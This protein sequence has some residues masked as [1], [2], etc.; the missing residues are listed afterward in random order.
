VLLRHCDEV[1]KLPD[2]HGKGYTESV[3]HWQ[4]KS[5]LTVYP[6]CRRVGLPE[7]MRGATVNWRVS[8]VFQNSRS[9]VQ[10]GGSTASRGTG[11]C[12]P[13]P[14]FSWWWEE[15]ANTAVDSSPC[16]PLFGSHDFD[17]TIVGGGYTGLWTALTLRERAP[18]LGVALLEAE[19]CGAGASGKNGGFL[20]GYWEGFPKIS[21]L[22]GAA[23]A[24]RLARMGSTA[25]QAIIDFCRA[26][27]EDVWLTTNGIYK[28]AT[29]RAQEAVIDGAI[30][31][32]AELPA[33][34]QP[35]V[36]GAAEM[37]RRFSTDSFRRAAW[38][39]EGGTVHP[40]RLVQA[41]K[42]AALE[43]GVRIFES[44][45][46]VDTDAQ[47][48]RTVLTTSAGRITSGHVVMATNA[49]L[50]DRLPYS[51]HVTNLGS[52]VVVTEPVPEVLKA[53]EGADG[54]A[55]KDARMFLNWVRTTPDG[56]LVMGNGAGP[57]S[58]RG[59]VSAVHTQ[60]Q[61][62]ADRAVE[63]LN[64]FFPA[65]VD[66]KVAQAW[67]GAIDMSADRLPFFGTLPGTRVHYGLGY[68]GHG[69]N[70]AW[71]GGQV[72]ASLALGQRDEWTTSLFC[73]RPLAK[74]PTEPFRYVGG[75]LIHRSMLR[76]EDALDAGTRPP[77]AVSTVA[78]LP[79]WLGLRIGVR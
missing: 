18:H 12:A 76:Y 46:V 48:H 72:L 33:E 61:P 40:V 38:F 1:A 36:V 43:A 50:S 3:Y 66:A 2:I 17:V 9:S 77:L 31:D 21:E 23:A 13:R 60:H 79:R 8:L 34:Y 67:G 56:R 74:F 11:G 39:P 54:L 6:L 45:P 69:V 7:S 32:G 57:M 68:S 63:A 51:R 35:R 10:V 28:A 42:R 49:W 4:G 16:P 15:A 25:Q 52:Y 73:E 22:F 24:L 37:S 19:T 71:I 47:P 27:P 44:S 53:M 30:R 55:L 26:R 78:A 65:T 41:M 62:S 64:Q 75:R 14:S 20:H 5:Y 58:Y 29:S 70:A 59:L